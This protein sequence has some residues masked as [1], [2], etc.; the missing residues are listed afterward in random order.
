MVEKQNTKSFWDRILPYIIIVCVILV[1]ICNSVNKKHDG[2]A[3]WI[4]DGLPSGRV[5]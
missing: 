5:Q 1:I 4:D 2:K 3:D